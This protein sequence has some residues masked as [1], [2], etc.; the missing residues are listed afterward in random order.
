M[1]NARLIRRFLTPCVLVEKHSVPD[2]MGGAVTRWED[3]DGFEAA[4]VKNETLA[5]R[6]AEKQG[7]S[8]LYTVTFDAGMHLNFHDVFRRLEDGAVFRVTSNAADSQPPQGA[9]FAL[10]QV[11]AE[12]WEL[13]K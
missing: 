3:G 4:V 5:A 6:V 8:E 13:P 9:S 11:K 7:V 2:G 10:R 12:R 1:I